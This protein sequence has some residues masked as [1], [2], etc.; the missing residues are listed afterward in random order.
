[1][2]E[3]PFRNMLWLGAL[4]LG[5]ATTS[6]AEAQTRASS[7]IIDEVTVTARKRASVEQAQEIPVASHRA[8]RR[9]VESSEFQRIQRY[10]ICDSQYVI[11][12]N[13]HKPR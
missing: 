10:F 8:R 1:M 12:R 6:V 2:G 7:A 3:T 11:R 4:A 13:R 9:S 5:L